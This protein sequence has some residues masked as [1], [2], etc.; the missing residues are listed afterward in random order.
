MPLDLQEDYSNGYFAA[1]R[2]LFV[3][4]PHTRLYG[5]L[6]GVAYC[7]EDGCT[8]ERIRQLVLDVV[9]GLDM[10]LT[11]ALCQ[12]DEGESKSELELAHHDQMLT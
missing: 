12:Y 9:L 1:V 5:P 7:L 3:N 4:H 8:D 6:T 10:Y 11:M 2:S